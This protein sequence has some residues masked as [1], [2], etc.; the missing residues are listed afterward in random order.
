[1]KAGRQQRQGG[2]TLIEMLVVI[3]IIGILAA[4]T[5]PGVGKA[6]KVALKRRAMMEMNSIKLAVHQ[7]YEDHRY[8]PWGDPNA[9]NQARVGDDVW[10]ASGADQARVIQWLTGDNPKKKAYLQVPD[11]SRPSASSFQF[12]DP[13][14]EYY[15]I[16]MDRN[17][18]GAIRPDGGSGGGDYV[19]DQVLVYSL[20]DPDARPRTPLKTW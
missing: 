12:N 4:I 7:F 8:M 14:G 3:A 2:F 1:M 18:D 19:R 17:M 20:G 16:G 11:K 13:W 9:A 6:R 5:V 10:T 15:R